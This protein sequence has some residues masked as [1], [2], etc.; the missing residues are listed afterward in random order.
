M[1]EPIDTYWQLRLKRCKMA[2]EKNNFGVFMAADTHAAD[3]SESQQTR[4]RTVRIQVLL[5]AR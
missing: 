3:H 5:D 4:R 2:L 1:T